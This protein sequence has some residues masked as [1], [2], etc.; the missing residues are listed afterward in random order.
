VLSLVLMLVLM[1]VLVLVCMMLVLDAPA[2][3][4][5]KRCDAPSLACVGPNCAPE[6]FEWVCRL[7]S[8]TWDRLNRLCELAA[9]VVLVV[10]LLMDADV[11][12]SLTVIGPF[13]V[14]IPKPKAMNF[15]NPPA[16]DGEALTWLVIVTDEIGSEAGGSDRVTGA[17][18][19]VNENEFRVAFCDGEDARA[20]RENDWSNITQAEI[21][22]RTVAIAIDAGKD[23]D[24][25]RHLDDYV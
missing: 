2:T 5:L 1:L 7:A 19:F 22:N 12:R 4:K 21:E 16:V 10:E 25:G 6:A 3:E 20:S 11:L 18:L 14:D 8:S 23:K 17:V 13:V 15:P 24:N 9:E